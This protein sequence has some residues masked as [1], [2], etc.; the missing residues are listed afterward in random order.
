MIFLIISIAG[1]VLLLTVFPT[2]ISYLTKK[3]ASTNVFLYI[4]A[5]LY[6]ISW[7]LPSPLID[8]RDTSFITHLVGGGLFSGFV[9]LYLKQVLNWRSSW[10]VEAISLFALVSML[11]VANELFELVLVRQ[12]IVNLH[13]S[14]TSWDLLANT[15]GVVL[16]WVGYRVIRS[17]NRIWFLI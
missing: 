1:P 6:F 9:W 17:G 10:I 3:T 2:I 16:F 14:D 8:G 12:G 11:G 7:Y 13:L 15:I 4:S 5:F